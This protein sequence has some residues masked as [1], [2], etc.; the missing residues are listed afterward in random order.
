LEGAF[1][2]LSYFL[3]EI[4]N[5]SEIVVVSPDAGGMKRAQSFHKHF[6]YHGYEG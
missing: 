5:K 2:G 6:N 3:N 1:V 4:P